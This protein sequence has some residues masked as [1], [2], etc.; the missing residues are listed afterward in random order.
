MPGVRAVSFPAVAALGIIGGTQPNRA[1]DVSS[2]PSYAALLLEIEQAFGSKSR[3]TPV[4]HRFANLE[5]KM[6]GHAEMGR[7]IIQGIIETLHFG[8]DPELIDDLLQ[9]WEESMGFHAAIEHR[10]RTFGADDRQV[11]W[12]LLA[13]QFAA[14]AGRK[15][16]FWSL[17]APVAPG[18]S[19]GDLWFLPRPSPEDPSRLRLP[20][21]T[22]AE[23]W[24]DLLD[25]PLEAIWNND[26]HSESR[27]KNLQNWENG[28]LPSRINIDAAFDADW[29]FNYRGTFR[30]RPD[31]PLEARF[32]EALEF[33]TVGKKK[34]AEALAREIPAVPRSLFDAALS[35]NADEREWGNFVRAIAQR[36]QEP[37]NETVRRRFLLAR[38]VQDCHQRITKLIS[39]NVDVDTADPVANKVR[40]LW[41][42][43]EA[44][45]VFAI[46]A[47]RGCR[48]VAEGNRRFMELVPYWL[49]QGPFKS[50]MPIG[51][52]TSEEFADF[53][54]DR[55]RELGEGIGDL[56]KDGSLPAGLAQSAVD[57]DTVAARRDMEDLLAR[58]RN[59]V[60][61][62]QRDEADRLLIEVEHHP[63]RNE[64]PADVSYLQGR[65]RLNLS[66]ADGAR[67]HFDAAFDVS[68]QGGVGPVRKEA[69][70][71]C[72][73]M[74]MGFGSFEGKA[75]KYFRVIASGLDPSETAG[76][77]PWE[78]MAPE[79]QDVLF[80]N[81]ARMA[82]EQFWD[83]LY[84][85][86]AGSPRL[87][88]P[89]AIRFEE[90]CK[91]GL[92]AIMTGDRDSIRQWVQSNKKMLAERMQDVQGDT[93]FGL[94]L[95]MA[96]TADNPASTPSVPWHQRLVL[97]MSA[98]RLRA[99]LHLLAEELPTKALDTPDFKCQTP[100]MLAAVQGDAA[101][102]RIL[103][104]RKVEF[105]AQ[106][107]WGRTALHAAAANRS[108]ECY[109]L[110]LQ[111]GANATIRTGTSRPLSALASAVRFGLPQA[112]KA[113]LEMQGSRF[114]REE[115]EGILSMVSDILGNYK[116]YRRVLGEEG[117][118]VG[119]KPAY[120]MIEEA[121]CHHLG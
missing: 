106:D 57:K 25:C 110:I 107:L 23:W 79:S 104:D 29:R 4:K 83:G 65:H 113:T 109:L 51:A 80:R 46:E 117:R 108:S 84:H 87:R 119:P 68:R 1:N 10:T 69:A 7:D 11:A 116:D 64:F 12:L 67:K 15:Y 59:A 40:Q 82:S 105:D 60:E 70:Y 5:N 17:H 22:V 62:G 71:A 3:Q 88:R 38:V 24:R 95:K 16:A 118:Q 32:Q 8:H 74:T 31:K 49:A 6:S 36:W 86:Y 34:D 101:L 56:F 102:V 112:V 9:A 90:I 94:M 55:F 77:R 114:S 21:Q 92:G 61:A 96:N 39:P 85:P 50:V 37:S 44:S 30:D 103:L 45:Y 18:M 13:Y 58:L 89:A 27:I 53:L 14:W 121:L 28:T 93:V 43:V 54:T 72:L 20:V 91:G 75:E 63:R 97:K 99:G 111:K 73:G 35:G 98:P 26:Q 42:L 52:G 81:V 33:V 41:T 78:M 2:I 48:S 47:E 115:I 19:G 76:L 66:D 100:L 120:R